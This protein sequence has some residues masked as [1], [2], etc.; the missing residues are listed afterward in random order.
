MLGTL[1]VLS[2]KSPQLPQEEGQGCKIDPK[3]KTLLHGEG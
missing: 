1:Y 3:G 2:L